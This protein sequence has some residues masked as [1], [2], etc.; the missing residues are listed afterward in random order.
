V[1][2]FESQLLTLIVHRQHFWRVDDSD[3][4]ASGILRRQHRIDL[5][6]ITHQNNF[7]TVLAGGL[8]RAFH[9]R[10]RVFVTSHGVNDNAD[11]DFS[12][13]GTGFL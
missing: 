13:L 11:H 8:H 3:G 6:F 1:A 9:I 5:G 2:R 12:F 7:H 10:V 4:Q